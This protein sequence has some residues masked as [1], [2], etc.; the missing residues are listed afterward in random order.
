MSLGDRKPPNK[1][2]PLILGFVLVEQPR[3]AAWHVQ[4]HRF[5]VTVETGILSFGPDFK[6]RDDVKLYEP[7]EKTEIIL[8][9]PAN[10][11]VQSYTNYVV[12]YDARLEDGGHPGAVYAFKWKEDK[13]M[14]QVA[15]ITENFN[16][17][18]TV[19]D[20][21]RSLTCNMYGGVTI[22][23]M[24]A[25]HHFNH[26]FKHVA[27]QRRLDTQSMNGLHMAG[28]RLWACDY[29]EMQLFSIDAF[30]SNSEVVKICA[31]GFPEAICEDDERGLLFVSIS[32]QNKGSGRLMAYDL[33]GRY[34]KPFS[35]VIHLIDIKDPAGICSFPGGVVVASTDENKLIVCYISDPPTTN[36]YMSDG[37]RPKQ[38]HNTVSFTPSSE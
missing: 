22:G 2:G 8:Q 38:A 23:S 33:H 3:C 34:G 4:R 35:P 14:I 21:G 7:D 24:T 19:L 31:G 10:V 9:Y 16:E 17:H 32:P 18:V 26:A 6:T 1:L 5:V 11:V 36:R 30:K 12:V 13:K 27:T 37:P 15:K 20:A 25:I 29:K 28:R